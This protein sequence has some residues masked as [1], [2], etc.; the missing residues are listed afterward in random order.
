MLLDAVDNERR[1]RATW[2]AAASAKVSRAVRQVAGRGGAS[3]RVIA[4]TAVEA[5]GGE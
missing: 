3:A 5:A 1:R 2:R 4:G